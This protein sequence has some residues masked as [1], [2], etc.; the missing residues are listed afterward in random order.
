MN[1]N[2]DE[3]YKYY[4]ISKDDYEALNLHAKN[5]GFNNEQI[6]SMHHAAGKISDLAGNHADNFN[7]IMKLAEPGTFATT[8]NT[9]KISF[10]KHLAWR[11][12]SF[13]TRPLHW[14]HQRNDRQRFKNMKG[15]DE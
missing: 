3:G 15:Q 1:D 12:S 8:R 14:L 2:F 7:S 10:W 6:L 9:R 4:F 13:F 11:F 5:A